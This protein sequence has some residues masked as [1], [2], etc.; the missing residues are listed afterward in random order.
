MC[1]F[2]CLSN[3]T[4][5]FPDVQA[6]RNCGIGGL[7]TT[8]IHQI[9]NE[10]PHMRAIISHLRPVKRNF[11]FSLQDLARAK[12]REA[13]FFLTRNDIQKLIYPEFLKE[14]LTAEFTYSSKYVQNANVCPKNTAL[15]KS[16]LCKSPLCKSVLCKGN[17][18]Q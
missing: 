4:F 8:G 9:F 17:V 18:V 15:C 16:V 6:L 3:T 10:N 5:L 2:C 7:L 1:C 14:F 12:I 13:P 11:P